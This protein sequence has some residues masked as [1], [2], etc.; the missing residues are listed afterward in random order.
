[1]GTSSRNSEPSEHTFISKHSKEEVTGFRTLD[2][3]I[4]MDAQISQQ[5]DLGHDTLMGFQELD[6]HLAIFESTEN[7]RDYSTPG[8]ISTP[9]FDAT[10][11]SIEFQSAFE[12]SEHT[13]IVDTSTDR[14]QSDIKS[15]ARIIKDP[16][17]NTNG[18]KKYVLIDHV[19]LPGEV[20]E[21]IISIYIDL[22]L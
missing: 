21:W 15:R 18:N 22:S 1:M 3:E 14:Y 4:A 10:I 17:P 5:D 13:I 19:L 16:K 2:M 12:N 11:E 6:S 7:G 20:L 8:T 9:G